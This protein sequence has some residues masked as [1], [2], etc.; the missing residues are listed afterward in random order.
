MK[1]YKKLKTTII[2]IFILTSIFVSC[3]KEKVHKKFKEGKNTAVFTTK[4]VI[5]DNK[6][7]TNVFHYKEDGTWQFNSDDNYENFEDVAKIV[8]LGQIIKIDKTI[9]EIADLPLGYSASRKSKNEDWT[10]QKIK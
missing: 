6:E 2:A 9:L 5:V 4:F 7:I 1:H 3:Q 8:G 10:I